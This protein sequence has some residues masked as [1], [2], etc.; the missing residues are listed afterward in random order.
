MSPRRRLAV[1]DMLVLHVGGVPVQHRPV[2]PS[3]QTHRVVVLAA[4]P[5]RLACSRYPWMVSRRVKNA[6]TIACALLA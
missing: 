2:V 6:L 5:H 3:H 1:A 4:W